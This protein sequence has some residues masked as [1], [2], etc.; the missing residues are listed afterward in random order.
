MVIVYLGVIHIETAFFY[1]NPG[2]GSGVFDNICG[3]V[4]YIV[5]SLSEIRSR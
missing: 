4:A 5:S 3:M 2:L 1:S